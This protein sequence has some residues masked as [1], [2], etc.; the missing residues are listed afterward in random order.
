MP[1]IK[2]KD[3][4]AIDNLVAPL[5]EHLKNL[6]EPVQDGSVNYLVTKILKELYPTKY[7][8]LNRAIGVLECIKQEFYRRSVAP[9]EDEKIKE[10]GD[11]TKK[12][13]ISICKH[14]ASANP[15]IEVH[16]SYEEAVNKVHDWFVSYDGEIRNGKPY[17]YSD[18]LYD[19]DPRGYDIYTNVQM[20]NGKVASFTHSNGDG[21][22]G[23]IQE[24]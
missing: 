6:P 17:D 22:E 8:D 21:P 3:R 19:D 24:K 23:K 16:D 13:Y 9:Y 2:Q 14:N 10:N 18:A 15:Y 5:I 1:Y 7:F 11:V 4:P 20:H 12:Q